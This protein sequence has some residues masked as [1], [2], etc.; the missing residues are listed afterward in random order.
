MAYRRSNLSFGGTFSRLS[1][2]ANTIST[3]YQ[4][5]GSNV[6]YYYKLTRYFGVSAHYDLTYYGNIGSYGGR[7]DNRVSFGVTFNSSNV[8]FS[9]F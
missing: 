7:I 9:Y 8:P 4:S 5:S 2:I 1:S 6:S 3:A